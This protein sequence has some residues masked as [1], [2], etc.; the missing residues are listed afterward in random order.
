[1][2]WLPPKKEAAKVSELQVALDPLNPGQFFACCG[3]FEMIALEEPHALARFEL[4]AS[5]PRTAQFCVS[6][7][8]DLKSVLARL[9][10]ANAEFPDTGDAAIRPAT[11]S[12]NGTRLEL[13][14][15][16]DPF[17]EKSGNLKCWAGQVTTSNLFSELL[18]ML[19][20]ASHGADLFN[21]PRMAKAKFGVDPRSAWNA[22]DFGFSPNEHGADAATF[23]AVEVLAA[24]GLQG[25]RPKADR[26]DGVRYALWLEP[27]PAAVARMAFRAPWPGLPRREFEF[28]IAKRRQ[29]YKYFTFAKEKQE[30]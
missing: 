27:L 24:I 6:T 21:R 8:V 12:H 7:G 17:R 11:I 22:L 30:Q 3:L 18:P 2:V 26:R 29:S 25:F 14:W 15:W 16:L 5:R 23:P 4:D 20:E 10:V 1:M 28:S 13:D 19:D 9:R